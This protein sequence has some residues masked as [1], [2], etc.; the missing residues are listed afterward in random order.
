M[1]AP[2]FNALETLLSASS[3]EIA[4]GGGKVAA[5]FD[6]LVGCAVE[7]AAAERGVPSQLYFVPDD[8]DDEETQQVSDALAFCGEAKFALA[9]ALERTLGALAAQQRVLEEARAALRQIKE[10]LQLRGH[11]LFPSMELGPKPGCICR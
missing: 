3:T 8:G 7:L 11:E 2:S 10:S 5:S 9:S 1:N 6:E 4:A